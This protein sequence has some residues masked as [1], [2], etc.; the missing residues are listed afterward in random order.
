MQIMNMKCGTAF[1]PCDQNKKMASARRIFNKA[2]KNQLSPNNTQGK[3]GVLSH[4]D[5]D[6]D[7]L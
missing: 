3:L 5:L 6:L 4:Q 7:L 1:V 2:T